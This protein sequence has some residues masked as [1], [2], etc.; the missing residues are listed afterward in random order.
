MTVMV[1]VEA[2]LR[3]LDSIVL[4]SSLVICMMCRNGSRKPIE[5]Q[6]N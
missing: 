3:D 2:T 1:G 6:F 4:S 5:L